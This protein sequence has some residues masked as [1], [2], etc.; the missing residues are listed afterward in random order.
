MRRTQLQQAQIF[1]FTQSM[2]INQLKL[3]IEVCLRI[4]ELVTQYGRQMIK[5][6]ILL[7]GP[8]RKIYPKK[9]IKVKLP[10]FDQLNTYQLML[11]L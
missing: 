9:A 1:T 4:C 3:C 2:R 11:L 10:C 7:N 8:S 6:L 5:I